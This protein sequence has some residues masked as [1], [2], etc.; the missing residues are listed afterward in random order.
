MTNTKKIGNT[1]RPPVLNHI[2]G[3]LQA[4]IVRHA[5]F[6]ISDSKQYTMKRLS[7]K[8]DL[9]DD[10]KLLCIFESDTQFDKENLGF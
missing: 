8:L 7:V 2:L 6:F 4:S 9:K 3:A 1:D 5:N 10:V